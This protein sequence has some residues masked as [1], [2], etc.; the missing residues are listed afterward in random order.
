MV[1]D[2][3][4]LELSLSE[5]EAINGGLWGTVL[6]A[7]TRAT[8]YVGT[9]VLVIDAIGYIADIAEG[10]HEGATSPYPKKTK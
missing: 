5:T 2:K 8:P 7:C 4:L 10:I 1:L 6:K 3:E 9:A